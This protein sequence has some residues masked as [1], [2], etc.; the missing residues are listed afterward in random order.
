MHGRIYIQDLRLHA[1]HG[2]LSQE[3]EVGNDY[4]ISLTVDYPIATACQTDNVSDTMSYADAAEI[5]KQEMV[6]QSNLLENVVH[7]ICTAILERFPKATA[8]TADLRK[9]APPMP[10][11]CAAAGVTLTMTR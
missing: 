9:V 11:D 6:T 4:I 10:V 2:V 1:Y 5:I 7:R 8:V 3:R